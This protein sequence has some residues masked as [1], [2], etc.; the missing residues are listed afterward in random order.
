MCLPP[1]LT[2]L[3]IHQRISGDPVLQLLEHT[4]FGATAV[5]SVISTFNRAARKIQ[6]APL[7]NGHRYKGCRLKEMVPIW[8]LAVGCDLCLFPECVAKGSRFTLWGSGG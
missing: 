1:F 3:G 7:V 6:Q 2:N 4:D 8:R 5:L